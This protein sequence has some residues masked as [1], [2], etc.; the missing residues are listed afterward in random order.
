MATNP[1]S[2]SAPA[3]SVDARLYKYVRTNSGWKYC[4]AHYDG[5]RLVPHSVFPPKSSSPLVIEGGYY[6]AYDKDRFNKPVW[7]RL[8]E[9]SQEAERLFKLAVTSSQLLKLHAEAEA[10]KNGTYASVVVCN[11]KVLT[12]GTALKKYLDNIWLQVQASA[13]KRRTYE[14]VEHILHPFCRSV[15][16]EKPVE[17]ISREMALTYIG[18]LKTKRQTDCAKT[19]KQNVFIYIQNFLSSNEMDVFLKGDCPQAPSESSEDIRMY[20]DEE[21]NA[22]FTAASPYHSMCWKTYLMSG[23]RE[24]ELTHLYKHDVRKLPDGWIIRV[25][26]KPA[27]NDWSPKT[28]EERNIYIPAE[29]GEELVAFSKEY[30]PDSKLLFPTFPRH[31]RSGGK[32]NGKLLDALNRDA[33]RAGLNPEDFW[34]HAFRSTCATRCLRAGMDIADCRRQLGHSPNSDT[35]WKYVQAARGAQRQ[36]A[37]EKVWKKSV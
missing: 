4:R 8:H 28:H 34:L 37:V 17:S 14:T 32:V 20:T 19:T 21:M 26:G 16:L 36:A 9:D 6:V 11:P 25:E 15:G 30:M 12:V 24:H 33:K 2:N 18:N 35:I 13:K 22:L 7:H 5:N 29:L 27:L 31:G 1:I 23:M 10:L 3:L